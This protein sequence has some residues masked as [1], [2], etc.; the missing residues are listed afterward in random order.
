MNWQSFQD[1]SETIALPPD[2]ESKADGK[3]LAIIPKINYGGSEGLTFRRFD[4]EGH[5]DSDDD[6]LTKK[7]AKGA[8]STFEIQDD[9]LKKLVFQH[10]FGYE[11]NAILFRN[12]TSYKG[13]YLVYVNNDTIYEYLILLSVRRLKSYQGNLLSDIV[14]N[15]KINNEYFLR[16][17]NPLIKIV[18]I[19]M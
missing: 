2:W 11:R 13:Y 16:T 17:E 19:N 4:R 9:S 14:G 5:S 3:T 15:L 12:G 1:A 18:N 8:F 7:I 6:E 10:D